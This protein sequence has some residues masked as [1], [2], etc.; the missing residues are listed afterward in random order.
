MSILV[1]IN[2]INRN[3]HIDW[4]SLNVVQN[5]TSQVDKCNFNIKSVNKPYT[6]SVGDQVEVLDGSI[7]IFGGEIIR[8]NKDNLSV[9]SGVI[10]SV[11]C[12]D[13]EFSLQNI[14]ISE[15]YENM[16]IED[17]IADIFDN[18]V[19][20]FTYNNVNCTFEIKKIVFN[21][22]SVITA[23]KRLSEIVKYEYYISPVKDLNFFQKFTN[24]A[25]FNL[26]DDDSFSIKGSLDIKFDGSQISNVVKVR[27][28]EYDGAL[29]EEVL[30]AGAGQSSFKTKNKMSNLQ[31]WIDTGGGY[32]E[33]VVGVEFLNTF[34]EGFDVLQ[35]YQDQSF[36]FENGLNAGDLVKYSGNPKVRVLIE[37]EDNASIAEYG[38]REKIIQ[39][40]SIED[41]KTA[42][43]RAFAELGAYK[44]EMIEAKFKTYTAG[45]RSGQLIKITNTKFGLDTN[46]IIKKVAFKTFTNNSYIY[47]AYLT[48]ARI[49]ELVEI[50]MKLIEPD[51]L[52]S[53]D[54]EVA[55]KLKSN[56]Q[57][58]TISEVI[59]RITSENDS[60]TIEI[61]ENIQKDPLGADTM[62]EWVLA[63]YFPSSIT[64][65]KREGLL[66]ISLE[67]Y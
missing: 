47:E 32:V 3:D 13:Y 21:N 56:I 31:V 67:L 48:T 15:S 54:A 49:Y 33:Q 8:V 42:R 6:P 45:L 19:P 24:S 63:P 65:T 4:R 61:T 1:K 62:P 2:S 16:T 27:G 28:G 14:L 55:E 34:D 57:T 30:T 52:Q 18:Y 37:S 41:N 58:L 66:D 25:P 60:V 36:N 64:D 20:S 53:D 17:I 43:Q 38:R 35:N 7:T 40:T 39:D 22:V 29:F 44:Q 11:E 10:Y 12:V 9:P 50:L 26:T 51:P 5:L 23:L 59:A 46:F